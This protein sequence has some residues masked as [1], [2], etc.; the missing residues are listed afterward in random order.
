MN[1]YLIGYRCSGKTT[2]GRRLAKAV[3]WAFIDL[4]EK[5]VQ[6]A[7]MTIKTIVE[8]RGWKVFRRLEKE[9][10]AEVSKDDCRMIA[11][12][13]GVVLNNANVRTMKKKGKIIWLKVGP[14]TIVA[15]M[16]ADRQTVDFRP[17]LTEKPL[18]AEIEETLR[19]RAPYYQKAMDFDVDTDERDIEDICEA[20][21]RKLCRV[22]LEHT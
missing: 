8:N 2:V 12:G 19:A 20:I 16:A 15:R 14:Q 17:S 1:I 21:R 7:G 11:T 5:I 3:G 10:L 22:P 18:F 4:D 6:N 9:M 13:G